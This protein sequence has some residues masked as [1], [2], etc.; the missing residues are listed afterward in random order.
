MHAEIVLADGA[1]AGLSNQCPRSQVFIYSSQTNTRTHAH[2]HAYTHVGWAFVASLARSKVGIHNGRVNLSA[3]RRMDKYD[4][5]TR[6]PTLIGQ[7]SLYGGALDQG[8]DGRDVL[9]SEEG[10]VL[11]P[12]TGGER[13]AQEGSERG[14]R[15]EAGTG[16][17]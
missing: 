3:V 5:H 6:P 14:Q 4:T 12:S 17:K 10:G 8:V 16:S 7:A 9:H 2:T 13:G 11:Y 15:R 1:N